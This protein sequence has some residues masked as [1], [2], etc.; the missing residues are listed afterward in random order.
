MA[1][2]TMFR[3][4]GLRGGALVVSLVI[5][6]CTLASCGARAGDSSTIRVIQ[7]VP[8]SVT[9]VGP[10]AAAYLKLYPQC[11]PGLK[12]DSSV[13]TAVEQAVAAGSADIGIGSSNSVV[14]AIAA[15]LKAKIIGSSMDGW[16]QALIM[17]PDTTLQSNSDLKP[18]LKVGLT[19]FASA[20]H[21]AALRMFEE[22]GWSAS[23]YDFVTVGT[24]P[25][26]Q[27][28]LKA[29]LF[30]GFIWGPDTGEAM[31]AVG[32]AKVVGNLADLI[33][34]NAQ[35][36]FFASDDALANRSAQVKSFMECGYQAVRKL[37]AEPQIAADFFVKDAKKKPEVVAG[38]VDRDLKFASS[39]GR[40]SDDALAGVLDAAHRTVVET[41]SLTIGDVKKMYCYWRDL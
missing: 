4:L 32:N 41:A 30:D 39:D 1:Y 5:V 28:G 11:A 8:D 27:A 34:P 6:I 3:S 16:D 14:A 17:G 24:L 18:P 7:T 36:V 2:S 9:E 22:L 19:R 23:D 20:G 33:G 10:Q 31:Q 40:L 15:G 29:D 13:G 35:T 25:S 38:L 26:L 37:K 21:Y 12:V